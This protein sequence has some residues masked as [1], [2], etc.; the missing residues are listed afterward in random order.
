MPSHWYRRSH[1]KSGCHRRR[2]TLSGL[3]SLAHVQAGELANAFDH[4]RITGQL[5]KRSYN[6]LIN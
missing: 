3:L 2:Q 5:C 6:A 1:L 4:A